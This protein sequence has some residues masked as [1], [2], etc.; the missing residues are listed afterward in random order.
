MN[1]DDVIDVIRDAGYGFVAT[2]DGDQPR[3]RPLM[4]YFDEDY[5]EFFIAVRPESRAKLQIAENAKVEICFVDRTMS[6]C[7]VTGKANVS[8]DLD[9]KQ[10]IWDNSPMM[11][12]F[13][14]G[15]EDETLILVVVIPEKVEA[16]TP[17]SELPEVISF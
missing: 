5:N 3:V 16:M 1:K 17:H 11:K 6:F 9:K 7:R 13:F 2:I 10:S 15:P 12:Q 8:N 14:A 4:P